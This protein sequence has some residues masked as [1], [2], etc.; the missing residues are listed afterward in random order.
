MLRGSFAVR[1][2]SMLVKLRSPR[3]MCAALAFVA[4]AGSAR[5]QTPDPPKPD[6]D[7]PDGKIV[8]IAAPP[9][10]P[11]QNKEQAWKMLDA[12]TLDKNPE[13]RI[14]ALAAF[15][16]MGGNPRSLGKIRTAMDDKDLDVRIAATLAAGQTKST[17]ITTDLRRMLDDR[18]ANE[19]YTAAVTLWKIHDR[20]GED[21]LTAVADGDRK[22]SARLTDSTSASI[23]KELHD[24]VGLAKYGATQ[25]AYAL[26]G[27]F[28][29]GLTAIEYVRKNGGASSRAVAIEL[30]AQNHTRPIHD[31][32]MAALA[33]KDVAVRAAACKALAH[34]HEADVPP[35]IARIFDDPK[36]PVRLAAAAA[37]LISS[38][39][40]TASPLDPEYQPRAA[41]A[42]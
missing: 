29:M 24:P 27:P 23:Q 33:D 41:K 36:P 40:V 12:A 8:E 21:I 26:L 32:L 20:S 3:L 5:C 10:T 13:T 9:K 7:S 11:A 28:G 39:A 34:Y 15:G 19:A 4:L 35:A 25:G 42:Q 17:N 2:M 18:D 38:G 1:G 16:T 6:S 37:Y 22:T 31:E 30:I 14:Q